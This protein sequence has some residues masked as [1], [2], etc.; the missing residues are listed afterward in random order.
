MTLHVAIDMIFGWFD[1]F[2]A[3]ERI[4]MIQWSVAFCIEILFH[5]LG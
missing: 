2:S 1:T 5:R 4:A 3:A